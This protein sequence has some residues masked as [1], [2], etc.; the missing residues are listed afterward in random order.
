M[1]PEAPTPGKR[2]GFRHWRQIVSILPLLAV[3]LFLAANLIISGPWLRQRAIAIV[4]RKFKL[5]AEI[6]GI[7]WTPWGGVAIHRLAVLQPAPLRSSMPE[8]LLSIAEIRFTPT[9]KALLKRRFEVE[10]LTLDTPR[11]YLPIEIMAELLKDTTVAAPPPLI[12]AAPAPASPI[13]AEP[14]HAATPTEQAAPQPASPTPTEP[15]APTAPT[16][17]EPTPSEP[18][19]SEPATVKPPPPPPPAA[20]ALPPTQWVDLKNASC[21]IVSAKKG[22]SL[23]TIS[24]VS[25]SIPVYG[26]SAE[27]TLTTQSIS[28]GAISTKSEL[29]TKISWAY[30]IFSIAPFETQF[31]DY[32]CLF[33][34]KLAALPRLPLQIEAQFSPQRLEEI[35][36]PLDMRLAAE[37]IAAIGRFR[38]LMLSPSTWDGDFRTELKSA[39]LNVADQVTHFDHGGAITL[40]RGGILSCVDA[41]L[42]GDNLSILGN[43]TLVADGRVAAVAR[44]VSHRETV[45]SIANRIFSQ[46]PGP[47]ALTELNTPQRVA[48]DLQAAGTLSQLL[49]RLGNGGP[50][51]KA[52]P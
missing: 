32:K 12:A 24:G 31:G 2:S 16:P 40:L 17:S 50:I 10:R 33:S 18:A 34:A 19:P 22:V 7:T 3:L 47:R 11:L 8:P 35:T 44:V 21:V 42:V 23:A 45:E 46:V 36:L 13:T 38:G 41:R 20:S 52:Q 6:G 1:T 39:I 37:S 27:S 9:W 25:G 30:P 5:P 26:Q 28:I 29:S 48:F 4:E 49:I 51:I 43:G 15:A 14:T